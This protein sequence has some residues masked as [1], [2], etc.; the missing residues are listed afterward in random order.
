MRIMLI[1][2]MCLASGLVA[3]EKAP[4]QVCD[5]QVVAAEGAEVATPAEK[6]ASDAAKVEENT[7]ASSNACGSCNH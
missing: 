6:V 3:A 4:E 2:M 7:L 5:T 1:S